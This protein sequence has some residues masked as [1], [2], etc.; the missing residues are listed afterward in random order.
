MGYIGEAELERLADPIRKSAYG[1][2]LLTVLREGRH[3]F[4]AT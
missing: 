2:Y 3:A 1:E 4:H